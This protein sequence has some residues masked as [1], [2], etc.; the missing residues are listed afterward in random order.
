MAVIDFRGGEP[1]Y[2]QLKE[3]LRGYII[4]GVFKPDERMPSVRELAS[5]LSVN[6]NT[7]Q[8]AYR[9]LEEEGYIYTVSGRG[10]F[11]A[12]GEQVFKKRCDELKATFSQTVKELAFLG[13]TKEE[14]ITTVKEAYADDRG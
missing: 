14:L 9:E 5:G 4:S 12:S 8:R 7:I 6:P 13:V 2:I 1:V 10:S 3:R 11:A